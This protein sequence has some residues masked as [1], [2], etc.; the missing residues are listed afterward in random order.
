MRPHKIKELISILMDSPLYLILSLRER[1]T[2]LARLCETYPFL[3]ETENDE[4]D[5][6]YE[7]SWAGI[8]SLPKTK[9]LNRRD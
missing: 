8:I 5:V 6:G 2:L 9:L 4:E 1:Y 7:A 3:I